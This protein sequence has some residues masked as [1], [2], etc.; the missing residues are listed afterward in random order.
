MVEAVLRPLVPALG[1]IR[2]SAGFRGSLWSQFKSRFM[3]LMIWKKYRRQWIQAFR[4]RPKY[5]SLAIFCCKLVVRLFIQTNIQS[6]SQSDSQTVR[7]SFIHSFI[8]P[9]IHLFRQSVSQSD[10]QSVRQSVSQ[11]V[12]PSVSESVIFS[13]FFT[14][15]VL[16]RFIYQWQDSEERKSRIATLRRRQRDLKDEFSAAKNRLLDDNQ[17]WS[18]G[19]K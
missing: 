2:P 1:N 12:N 19:R 11:S 15:F 4:Y 13:L 8:H 18:Y 7:R 17:R 16:L 5:L 6:V 14:D 9:F 3:K 10:T